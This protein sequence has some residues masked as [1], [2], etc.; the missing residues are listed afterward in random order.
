M[1]LLR[2][3]PK[4]RNRDN[5]RVAIHDG[6]REFRLKIEGRFAERQVH[7][8]ESCWQ[9][10]RSTMTGR[11]FAVELT[12]VTSVDESAKQLLVR[13]YQA[14]A[15]FIAGTAETRLVVTEVTGAPPI[16]LADSRGYGLLRRML[17]RLPCLLAAIFQ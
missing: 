2:D 13:M 17:N 1:P 3:C 10:A 6:A 14:G 5:T 4:N 11:R 12:G 7:E 15:D 9:T 16:E 8:A